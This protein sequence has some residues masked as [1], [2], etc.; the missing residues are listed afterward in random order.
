MGRAKRGLQFSTR[1]LG[2][3]NSWSL[4]LLERDKAAKLKLQA[5]QCSGKFS[6]KQF[7]DV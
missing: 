6:L 4:Q 7:D 5:F 3:S 1:N 2:V